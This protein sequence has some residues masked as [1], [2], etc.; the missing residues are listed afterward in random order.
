MSAS[1][2]IIAGEPSGDFLGGQLAKAIRIAQ[3]DAVLSGVGG[4]HMAKAGIK[5]LFG[6]EDL[7]VMGV[8]EILPNLPTILKRIRQTIDFIKETKPDVVV[9]IDS[10]DFCFRVVKALRKEM[11]NPPKFVH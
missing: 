5:S 2:A 7:A 11:V 3:P 1:I 6:Y 10:P 8:A 9:T 4:Q